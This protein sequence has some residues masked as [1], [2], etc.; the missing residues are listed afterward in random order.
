[1]ENK[2]KLL[3]KYKEKI[4]NEI[5]KSYKDVLYFVFNYIYISHP[6]RGRIPFEMYDFQKK[7]LN[8]IIKNRFNIILKSRQMGISTLIAIYALWLMIFHSDT[9][10]VV[11]AINQDVAKNIVSKVRYAYQYLPEFFKK[12]VGGL[13]TDN[14]MSLGFNNHSSIKA[15]T[16]SDNAGRSEAATV[17]I[18]DEAAFIDNI[19]TIWTS[20][21]S[22]IATGGRA[23]WLSTPNGMGNLFHQKWI[24][25]ES[26]ENEFNPIKLPWYLHPERDEEWRRQQTVSLGEKQAAQECDCDFIA[27][28]ETF[29]ENSIIHYYEENYVKNPLEKRGF[30]GNFWI[31]DYPDYSKQYIIACDVARGD[32]E[33]YST[34]QVFEA[35]DL[36][37]VAEYK[38]QLNPKDFG[39]FAVNVA[40]EYNDAILVI[41]NTGIGWSAI[42]PAIDRDYENLFYSHRNDKNIISVKHALESGMDFY[43]EH[44]MVPG[45]NT[46]EK[47]RINILSK[48][49]QYFLDH[50]ITIYSS[51]LINELYV[52]AWI[53]EKPQ[54][55]KGYSDDLVMALSIMLWVRDISLKLRQNNRDLTKKVI[56]NIGMY[57]NVYKSTDINKKKNPYLVNLG[58]KE[59]D[60]S[61][62][63]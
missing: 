55:R 27:S 21:Q 54:A 41:E 43:D 23:V 31:W 33:D 56:K 44:D 22:T 46:K 45:F 12:M 62:L 53:R 40:T 52:F 28:G 4:K 11:V 9:K 59:E 15:V 48:L 37:Q 10:V 42:Q 5:K 14:R 25:A 60:I 26:G 36:I 24:E 18:I 13:V 47:D 19:Q 51:R 29:I 20:V 30:D 50:S 57:K 61:W 16:S 2:Q 8:E 34:I 39:N 32:G 63:L 17:L 3:Q 38:G 6:K 49:K 58:G 7:T 1:M 35:E